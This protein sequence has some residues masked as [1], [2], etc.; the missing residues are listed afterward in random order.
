VLKDDRA[1]RMG[2]ARRIKSTSDRSRRS[3]V[4]TPREERNQLID[5]LYLWIMG[6]AL[7]GTWGGGGGWNGNE[8]LSSVDEFW[9]T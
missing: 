7:R 6:T 3:K 2:D 8:C 9:N 5:L 1:V 4:M